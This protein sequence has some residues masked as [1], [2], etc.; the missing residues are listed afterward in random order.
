MC[1]C[2]YYVC[3]LVFMCVRV[4]CVVDF[5]SSPLWDLART[6]K[7][8]CHIK[9]VQGVYVWLGVSC[10]G[11]LLSNICPILL[12][13]F[14]HFHPWTDIRVKERRLQS[15]RRD[16]CAPQ[17][18]EEGSWIYPWLA[19]GERTWNLYSVMYVWSC[20]LLM[21]YICMGFQMF[22]TWVCVFAFCFICG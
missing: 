20:I 5:Q 3:V 2:V 12:L 19:I 11:P 6:L 14:L 8:S 18:V 7:K 1:M 17:S 22:R 13:K 9:Q 10:S 16:K 21:S 15:L 4:W